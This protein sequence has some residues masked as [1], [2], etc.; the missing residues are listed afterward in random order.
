MRD[1][2]KGGEKP[3]NFQKPVQDDDEEMKI[4]TASSPGYL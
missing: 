4:N 1:I 2:V 3:Q